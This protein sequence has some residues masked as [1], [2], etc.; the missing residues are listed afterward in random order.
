M[1][2][3]AYLLLPVTD[4]DTWAKNAVIELQLHRDRTAN[5]RLLQIALKYLEEFVRDF[6]ICRGVYLVRQVTRNCITS[7][8]PNSDINCV[9]PTRFLA[10]TVQTS[11][12]QQ[13]QSAGAAGAGPQPLL[14]PPQAGKTVDNEAHHFNNNNYLGSSSMKH[15]NEEMTIQV[16]SLFGE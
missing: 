3:V 14:P 8:L 4:F 10:K 16:F 2:V 13:P 6:R 12:H 11:L 1:K 15:V 5:F 9:V 7:R